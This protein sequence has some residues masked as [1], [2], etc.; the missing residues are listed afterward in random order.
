MCDDGSWSFDV[1]CEYG[2]SAG[3]CLYVHQSEC[4]GERWEYEYIRTPIDIS[5]F[6]FALGSE[7]SYFRKSL[8]K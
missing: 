5:E 6:F 8:L 3:E 2:E 7:E 1:V 4:I